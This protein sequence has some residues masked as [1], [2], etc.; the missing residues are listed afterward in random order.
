LLKDYF[1]FVGFS[2]VYKRKGSCKQCGRCCRHVYLRDRGKLV[3][4][5]HEC[6]LMI[7]SD[8]DLKQFN[9]KGVNEFGE[10]FFAC[11]YIGRDNKCTRYKDRPLLCRTYPNISMVRYGAV[12]K[13][14]CGYY[15]VNRFTGKKVT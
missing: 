7:Q 4:S 15:F 2:I 9:V 10:L 12:P 3:S 6:L 8:R 5:F 1:L 14:D 13:E 11:N